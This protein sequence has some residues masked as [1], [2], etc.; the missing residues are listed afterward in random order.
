MK[1]IQ[2]Q[3]ERL[4]QEEYTIKGAEDFIT[5]AAQNCTQSSRERDSS[6]FVENLYKS[7]HTTPLEFGTLYLK[8]ETDNFDLQRG[9]IIKEL[10]HIIDFYLQDKYSRVRLITEN[11]TYKVYITTNYLVFRKRMEFLQKTKYKTLDTALLSEQT[12]YHIPRVT[13]KIDTSI[14]IGRELN[15]Y[16]THSITELSTRMTVPKDEPDSL[17]YAKPYWIEME[18]FNHIVKRYKGILKEVENVYFELK[19]SGIPYDI[20]RGVLPLDTKSVLWHCAYIDDWQHF[21]NQR[22]HNSTGKAHPDIRIIAEQIDK[23]INDIKE[24]N[25]L[26]LNESTI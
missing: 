8:Y 9:Y 4:I 16:R 5:K 19:N 22:L 24:L 12:P 13:F 11:N 3:V 21:I 10:Y 23:H 1:F 18:E 20:C 2:P 25:N 17:S 26:L 14:G 15:R 6:K 7:G